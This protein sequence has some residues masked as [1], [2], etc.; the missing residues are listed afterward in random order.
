MGQ[1][2]H[3]VMGNYLVVHNRTEVKL[4]I[5]RISGCA[6]YGLNY[7]EGYTCV[8]LTRD[9]KLGELFL[10]GVQMPYDTITLPV[11]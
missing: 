9:Y 4:V 5:N 7:Q 3:Q 11:K 6:K 10:R 8:D 2:G 1:V